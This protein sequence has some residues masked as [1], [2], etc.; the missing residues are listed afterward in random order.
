MALDIIVLCNKYMIEIDH[1]K[2]KIILHE[3]T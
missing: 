3:G 1:I 2:G